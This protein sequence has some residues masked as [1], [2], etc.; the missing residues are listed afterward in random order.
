M[1]KFKWMLPLVLAGLV[2]TSGFTF[3]SYY[4]GYEGP[5]EHWTPESPIAHDMAFFTTDM[6]AEGDYIVRIE[7][8]ESKAPLF[9]V[10][11]QTPGTVLDMNV[12][13][14]DGIIRLSEQFAD[15]GKY[16]ITIQ[17][18]IHPDHK[19][20]VDFTVQTPLFKYANDILLIVFLAL[21]GLLS[22]SR[23]RGLAM[24]CLVVAASGFTQP[25]SAMAHGTGGDIQ[26]VTFASEVNGVSLSWLQGNAPVGEANRKPMDW[27]MQISK[28]G[29]PVKRAAYILDIIHIES[30]HPVLH[31]EG[32]AARGIVN[33]KY[34]PPD[35]TDYQLQVR[36][37]VDGKV[38][39][40]ALEAEAEAIRPTDARKWSSFLLMM[41]PFLIGLL[42]GWKRQDK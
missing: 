33:L 22:G 12:H 36:T 23:L 35:G 26:S 29:Q 9:F 16:R 25:Q 31:T 37:V 27:R 28:D 38:Y 40:L 11:Y 14:D 1:T 8:L 30:G 4:N 13:T 39:H 17:H 10:E 32:V 6:S 34:S 41:V 5:G 21:A 15:E 3:V 2:I 7:K 20:V 18:T 24:I 42:W 19:E